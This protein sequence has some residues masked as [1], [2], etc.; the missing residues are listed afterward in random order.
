MTSAELVSLLRSAR[1]LRTDES[2]LQLDVAKLLDQA[3][4]RYEREKRFDARDRVDFMV[5][6]IALELKVKSSEK[7]LLRQLLRYS[8]QPSVREIVVAGTC[9]SVLRLPRLANGKPVFPCHLM[10][11]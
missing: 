10:S 6:D 2:A 7:E 4:V 11:W 3:G 8:Q 5:G 9:H 1:F